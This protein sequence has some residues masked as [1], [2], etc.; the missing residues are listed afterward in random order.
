MSEAGYV[1]YYEILGLPENAS[2]GEVRKTYKREMKKLV[3]EIAR[4]EITEDRRAHYLLEMA[5]LNAGLYLLRDKDRREA[6]WL[7]RGEL[8]EIERQWCETVGNDAERDDQIRREYYAKLND[9]L[10]TYVEEAMLEAGRD[11]ECVETSHWDLAH[12][13]HSF[14]IL[15]HYRH[16]LYRDILERLPYHDVTTPQIDWQERRS[17]VGTLLSAGTN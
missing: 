16:M 13:R 9:F 15:R 6:Y 12:E 7:L 8:I 1:N 17:T 11:K 4:V 3:Q 2:P 10:A 14:R 5:K